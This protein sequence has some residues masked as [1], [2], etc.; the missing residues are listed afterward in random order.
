MGP[1]GRGRDVTPARTHCAP[2][3]PRIGT[4][5]WRP[6]D[7]SPSGGFAPRGAGRVGDERP[8]G[9]G[10]WELAASERRRCPGP[11]L[12]LG[13]QAP[14]LARVPSALLSLP[15]SAGQGALPG[16]PCPSASLSENVASSL[17]TVGSSVGGWGCTCG[18][19]FAGVAVG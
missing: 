16:P 12:T 3:F 11:I 15:G 1:A 4:F 14:V 13:T 10:G 18:G 7:P 6:A 17:E 9:A 5:P 8:G 19:H 2:T